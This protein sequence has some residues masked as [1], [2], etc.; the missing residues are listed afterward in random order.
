[1]SAT[2]TRQ[3][4]VTGMNCQG[5]VRSVTG[6]LRVVPGVES[7]DVSLER[8]TATVAYDDT[9]VEATAI[10]AAIEAAGFEAR[11]A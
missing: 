4:A 9:A 10:V 1:M 3:F 2:V 5:C 11:A 8:A 6:A 7:V